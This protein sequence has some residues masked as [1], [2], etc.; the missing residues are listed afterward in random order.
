MIFK[1]VLNQN[2]KEFNSIWKIYLSSFPA[3]ERRRREREIKLFANK[4]YHLFAISDK[5][6]KV[7]EFLSSWNFKD[8]IFIEHFAVK[9][10]LRKKGLGKRALREYIS[11]RNKNIILEVEK[12]RTKIA[13]ERIRFYGALGFKLNNYDYVQ[14]AYCKS[15]KSIK[16]FLM[17]FP[18]KL[19]KLEFYKIKRKIYSDV[20]EVKCD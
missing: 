20:Y 14:P 5:E 6:G 12:P 8:F 10:S 11:K 1:R 3:N 7:I 17:S 4:S 13:Q 19:N 15:K 9:N 18:K 2:S 16:L